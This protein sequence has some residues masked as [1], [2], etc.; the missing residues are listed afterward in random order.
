MRDIER[1]RFGIF[2]F[3]RPEDVLDKSLEDQLSPFDIILA[4]LILA[5]PCRW[6]LALEHMIIQHN[7]YFSSIMTYMKWPTSNGSLWLKIYE[8]HWTKVE[9]Q[10]LSAGYMVH[11][12]WMMIVPRVMSFAIASN[13]VII[14][15][16]N[17]HKRCQHLQTA[18][19]I[20]KAFYKTAKEAWIDSS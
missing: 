17:R 1:T 20:L 15:Y 14:D 18:R 6:I 10:V 11:F 3:I 13:N 5:L 2:L 7:S 4:F 16:W 8:M 19:R 12:S 9:N